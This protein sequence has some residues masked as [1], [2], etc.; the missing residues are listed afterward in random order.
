MQRLMLV[1]ASNF[2]CTANNE[3]IGDLWAP[4]SAAPHW[5]W[6]CILGDLPAGDAASERFTLQSPL[7]PPAGG[8]L[9]SHPAAGFRT[10]LGTEGQ[11][12]GPSFLS[13]PEQL[14]EA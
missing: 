7:L 3:G 11:E 1:F 14:L 8:E 10:P 13:S 5:D 12:R 2:A 9:H 4:A 6:G